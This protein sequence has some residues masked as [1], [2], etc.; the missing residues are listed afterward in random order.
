MPVIPS[1]EEDFSWNKSSSIDSH[2]ALSAQ[3]DGLPISGH[4]KGVFKNS[5]RNWAEFETLE[6]ELIIPTPGYVKESMARPN[7]KEFLGIIY[8]RKASL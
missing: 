4:F 5:T 6:T 2:A 1:I 3:M 7:V 8:C